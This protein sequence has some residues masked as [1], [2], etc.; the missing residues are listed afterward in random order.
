MIFDSHVHTKFSA[1]SEMQLADAIKAAKEKG[2]G[3]VLTEHLDFDYPGDLVF[4]F[5]PA[6]YFSEYGAQRS[7]ADLRLGV[8][9]GMQACCVEKNKK[10][11]GQENFD[12][13][14]G[15][16]HLLE[17]KDIYY[18][19][20]Y[21]GRKK[22]EV[23]NLYFTEM[24]KLLRMHSFI[25][26]L[27]HIDYIARYAPYSDSNL[28]YNAFAEPIDALLKIA[29]AQ[30]NVL[31]LSTRRLTD[32][33][34]LKTLVPIYKRYYELGGRYVTIGSDAHVPEAVGGNFIAAK[35]LCTLIGLKIVSFYQ[36]KMEVAVK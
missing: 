12:M 27:G 22:M 18:P 17:G 19:E 3:L 8:E 15:S 26:V 23:Y 29:V 20:F 7:S 14:I 33:L 9:M 32:R 11:I 13:V 28:Q 1:D 4:K 6:A 24:A 5:N 35:E 36:R 10:F 2:I 21:K 16:V 25:D 30:G 34:A 31:E